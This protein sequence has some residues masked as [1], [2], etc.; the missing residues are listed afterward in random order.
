MRLDVE[1]RRYGTAGDP[2]AD[3][4]QF[5]FILAVVPIRA[6]SDSPGKRLPDYNFI[7]GFFFLKIV[8]SEWLNRITACREIRWADVWL[9]LR[10]IIY[11]IGLIRCLE[12]GSWRYCWKV[13]LFFLSKGQQAKSIIFHCKFSS[14]ENTGKVNIIL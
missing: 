11:N 9:L 12:N 8:S 13:L 7:T 14:L 1:R 3:H 4:F 2:H 10:R 5:K 6:A